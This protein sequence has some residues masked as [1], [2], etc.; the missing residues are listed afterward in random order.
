MIFEA[1]AQAIDDLEVPGS[2][3]AVIELT[4]YIERLEARRAGAIEAVDR[5]GE[6]EIEGGATMVSWLRHN[7]RMSGGAAKAAVAD[8]ALLGA[9]PVTSAAAAS[10]ALS[11]GQ[12]RAIVAN[13]P[14]RFVDLFAEG[15]A[16]L[17]PI[18]AG[19]GVAETV[20]VM[21]QWRARAEAL[22]DGPAE[23]DH[24]RT[25]SVSKVLDGRRAISGHLD[26]F[27]GETLDAALALATTRD[28]AAEI[29]TAAERRAD[30]LVD[31]CRF[32]LDNQEQKRGGRHRPHLNVVVDLDR[33]AEGGRFISGELA[34]GALIETLL[35]DCNLHRV[36][37][38]GR[39]GILDYGRSARSAPP[40]LFNALALRDGGCREPG[41]DRPPAWCDAH[42]VDVWEEGGVTKL[43][44]QV[45]RCSRH[46][47]QWHRRRK[48]GWTER[49][50]DDATLVITDTSGRTYTS[51]ANGPLAQRQ[52]WVS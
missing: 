50:E 9:L 36:L 41:C 49:L 3:D 33:V 27:G 8:A 51:Y 19:M 37:A 40:D 20:S 38:R 25:L 45:L 48:L 18:M 30:A 24:K 47:H 11:A 12:V 23:A 31:I 2:C 4:R 1:L 52:L 13:V 39:S 14:E 17:V 21:V 15:E 16:A 10:G 5:S 29:R 22:I 28:S 6:W 26:G 35:C 7:A 32:F 44:N 34:P 43:S 42:H 46:H